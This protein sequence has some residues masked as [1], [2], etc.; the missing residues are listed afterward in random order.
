MKSGLDARQY[1]YV[2]KINVSARLLLGIINDILDISKIESGAAATGGNRLRPA[3]RP[4]G[5]ATF[6][7]QLAEER[8]CG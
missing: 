7:S 5:M 8:A 4:R 1:E 2:R 3:Q 6:A